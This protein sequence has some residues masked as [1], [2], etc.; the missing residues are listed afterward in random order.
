[1]TPEDDQY[2]ADRPESIAEEA[3]RLVNGPRRDDYG[4]VRESF[5]QVAAVW[6][7]LLGFNLAAEDV[8]KL[9]IAYKLCRETNAAKRDN[10]V[11]LVGYTIL[12]DRLETE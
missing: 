10:R 11:D 4:P 2:T 5:D 7:A 8:A 6:S 9:M 12:L 1:M 3:E